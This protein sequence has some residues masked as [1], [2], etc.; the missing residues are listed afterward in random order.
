MTEDRLS[1]LEEQREIKSHWITVEYIDGRK[2][3]RRETQGFKVEE[4]GAYF[5]WHRFIAGIITDR[6][7]IKSIYDHTTGE[8]WDLEESAKRPPLTD[9]EIERI[10]KEIQN[11][12]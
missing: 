4:V 8:L 10:R 7:S 2:E 6:P 1:Q 3:D 9:Y 5:D 11:D 12:Y